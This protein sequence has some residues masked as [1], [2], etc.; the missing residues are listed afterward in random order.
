MRA[1][2]ILIRKETAD[3]NTGE[4]KTDNSVMQTQAWTT[5]THVQKP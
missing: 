5:D 3:E 4:I 2:I 1:K